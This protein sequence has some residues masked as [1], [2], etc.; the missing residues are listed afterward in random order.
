[1]TTLILLRHGESEG[2]KAAWFAGSTDVP[3]TDRGRQQAKMA[4]EYLK[5]YKIDT[6]Y[7]SDLQRAYDTALPTAKS[8][9]LSIIPD[10]FLREIDAGE[11]EGMLYEDIVK[12]F[13][14]NYNLWLT[15]IGNAK[16][17]GG[18]SVAELYARITREIQKIADENEGKTVCIATHATP[19]RMFQCYALGEPAAYAAHVPW[20][21]NA[22]VTVYTYDEGK[23]T[24]V[25]EGVNSYLGNLA[26]VFTKNV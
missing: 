7:A 6:I 19:I 3:L 23:Y 5:Q 21:P 16:T 11:W 9:G 14:E 17:D 2:N 12:K 4:S 26:T 25:C 10:K 1:M 22:S 20:V 13:G 15:D 24:L 8:Q 18:E